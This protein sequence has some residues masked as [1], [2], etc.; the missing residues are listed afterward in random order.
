MSI[1]F[2]QGKLKGE[3]RKS[4]LQEIQRQA[5]AAALTAVKPV[6]TT[7]LEAEVSAKLGRGKRDPRQVSGQAREID[8]QCTSCGSRDANQFIGD[9]HYRRD[10]ETGWGHLE[11]VQV[12]MLECQRCGQT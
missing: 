6:F 8:W 3:E 1:R 4:F 10:L 12:P 2:T 11:G 7:F 9:G 5:K